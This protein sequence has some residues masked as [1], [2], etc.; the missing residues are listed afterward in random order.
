MG[1][2][3]AELP[4]LAVVEPSD[5]GVLRARDHRPSSC[6]RGRAPAWRSATGSAGRRPGT[7]WP[8]A[9]AP[10]RRRARGVCRGPG[11]GG[12]VIR[13]ALPGAVGA[14]PVAVVEAS[15]GA[16][17]IAGSGGS[18]RPAA[19]G[20][21]A[22][23]RAVGVAAV[24]RRADGEGAV[25]VP[26]GLPAEGLVHGVGARGVVSDW[27]TSLN[28]GTTART[29]SVCRSSRR[30][31]GFGRHNRA[32]TPPSE[33]A[34]YATRTPCGPPAPGPWTP[35]LPMD[36]K[37]ALTGS[38]E[39][40]EHRRFPQRP[41]PRFSFSSGSGQNRAWCVA[42]GVENSSLSSAR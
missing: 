39:N 35:P 25:A 5:L 4:V 40:R 32:L 27:T 2:D 6:E 23:R 37:N 41:Q 18:D 26:A 16:A 24:A 29:G 30:S 15:L 31:R 7:G 36:A 19:G 22:P 10:G 9:R 8:A 42:T 14:L 3:G 33:S 11:C 28:R 34:L 17:L 1:C 38:L 21:A 20:R 12:S 13:H